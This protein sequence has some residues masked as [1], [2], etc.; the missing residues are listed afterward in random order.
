MSG[1]NPCDHH[2][3]L[4]ATKRSSCIAVN[5]I[6]EFECQDST[7][8]MQTMTKVIQTFHDNIKCGPEYVYTCCN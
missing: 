5:E 7:H 8:E 1:F 4:P 6:N 2:L 3:F